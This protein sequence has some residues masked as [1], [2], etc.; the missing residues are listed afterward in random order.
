MRVE[1]LGELARAA[2]C[3]CRAAARLGQHARREEAAPGESERPGEARAD[4]RA[5][6]LGEQV[7]APRVAL[8]P[9]ALLL[10]V[11]RARPGV[12][13]FQTATYASRSASS[14]GD[15]DHPDRFSLPCRFAYRSPR[16]KT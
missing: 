2:R 13:A 7:E 4:R 8:A 15:A 16:R 11:G 14:V 3:R 10:D 1:V 5:V 9:L 6:E 12:I